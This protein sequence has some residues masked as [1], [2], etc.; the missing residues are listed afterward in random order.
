VHIARFCCFAPVTRILLGNIGQ[1]QSAFTFVNKSEPTVKATPMSTTA[2]AS[3]FGRHLEPRERFARFPRLALRQ[4][5][6]E[7]PMVMFSVIVATAFLSMA[8]IPASG[9]AWASFGAPL[10]LTDE[11]G[12]TSKT[13]RLPLSLTEIACR[14][15]AWGAETADCITVI[16]KE[17]GQAPARKVR[18]LASA[19][20]LSHTPNIF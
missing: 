10:K 1:I 15:Q 4:R 17:T 6:N 13:Y 8:L 3:Q 5:S 7:H 18:M 11:A 20:P 16:A 9:P 12:T 14:G 19:E 2:T